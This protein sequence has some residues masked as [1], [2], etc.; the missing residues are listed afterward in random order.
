MI[1]MDYSRPPLCRVG[2][3][4]RRYAPTT[5]A[6]DAA[7]THEL[8]HVLESGHNQWSGDVM[9]EYLGF[10]EDIGGENPA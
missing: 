5:F 4:E 10:R 2:R 3:H 7:V 6:R 9:D 8:G 1:A